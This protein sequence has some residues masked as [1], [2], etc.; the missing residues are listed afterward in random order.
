MSS[1]GSEQAPDSRSWSSNVLVRTTAV[2]L[3]ATA[4]PIAS[5]VWASGVAKAEVEQRA[6]DGLVSTAKATVLQEQQAWEDAVRVITSAASRPV[7]L[8]ALQSRDESLAR[9][10]LQN[11]LITGPFADVRLFDGVG[12][13]VAEAAL[14]GVTPTPFGGVGGPTPGFGDPVDVGPGTARQVAVAIGP[15]GGGRLVVDVDVTQ[16]LGKPSDLAFG[17]TGLKFLVTSDGM[18]VAGSTAVGTML[19]SVLNRSIAAAGH[20]AAK[21]FH[22]PSDESRTVESYEPLPGPSGMGILVQQSRSEAMGGAD[23]LAGRLRWAALAVGVLGATFAVALGVFLSRRSRRLATSEARLTHAQAESRRRLEQ[24]LDAI[25]IGVFVATPDGQPHYANREAARLLGRGIVPGVPA[26]ERAEVFNAYVAGTSELYPVTETP[27]IRALEGKTTH[28]DDMEIRRQGVTVPVEVWGA[29]VL[30]GDSTVEFGITA[31]ADVSDRRRAARELQVLSAITAN[32]SEGVVLVR[33][34]DSTIAYA[35]GSYEAMF[36]YEPGELVGRC[37]RDL[38]SPEPADSDH[39]PEIRGELLA[40][41]TWRGELHGLRKDGSSLW[42][43]VN[44][45]ALEHPTLGPAWIQVTTD[46]T[47]RKLAQEGQARLASIVEA[48]RDAILG[49]TLDGV[50]TSWNH[51]AEV[52]F[53]YAAAEMIGGPIELLI[54]PEGRNDEAQVRARVAGG[55]GVEHHETVRVRK[56]G[57]VVDVSATLSPIEDAYGRIVGIAT[58]C[59][60]VTDR[61]RAE[62]KFQGLLESAPD[63]IVVVGADGLIRLVNRQTEVLFGWSR[64]EL[65]GRPVEQLMPARLAAHHPGQRTSYFANPS[66]RAMGANLELAARRKDGSEFPVDISLSPLETEEGVLVSAA[67]RD[68]T[69]R[70][71]AEAA[72]LDREEQLAAARDEAL[73]ASRLKSQFLANMSHEIRT[74]MNGVLG[75]AQLLLT[76][77]L[78]PDQRRRML[79]LHESGQSLLT[80]INDILDVSK[81]EAGKMELEEA[82]FNLGTTINSVV[83][84]CSSS[85]DD[86][87]LTLTV[88]VARGI[89]EVVRGDAFRLRQ[90]LVNIVGNAVKFTERG[91]VALRVTEGEAGNL[92]F[93]VRDTGIG[94]DSSAKA[95]LLEPFSQADASTTR[96]FGGTGL[97]LAICRQL[98]GL[99]GGSLDFSSEPGGGT[100][101]W[102]ELNLPAASTDGGDHRGSP[103]DRRTSSPLLAGGRPGAV[104]GLHVLLVDD[105]EINREVGKGLVESLGYEVDT[106]SSGAEA[107]EAVRRGDYTAVLMDCLMPAMDG[108]QATGHIRRLDGAVGH[109]PIIALTAAAMSHD[110]DRCLAAGMDDYVTKPLDIGRLAAVLGR[111]RPGKVTTP[112]PAAAAGV[113]GEAG[114][115][116]PG[117]GREAALADRLGLIKNSLPPEAF[118]RICRLFISGTPELIA[119]LD[120]ATRAGDTDTVRSVAHNLKG[121]MAT[122]GAARLSALAERLQEGAP[123]TDAGAVLR[124]MGEEYDKARTVVLSLMAPSSGG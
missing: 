113:A 90:I 57:T 48:S 39:V 6:V 56:D 92:R 7:P 122:V 54:P 66:V 17:K 69:E 55:L 12:N 99:M 34:D 15:G 109:V 118:D 77:N 43:A 121:T 18:I 104:S 33:A 64:S 8:S 98:V 53:G 35:N 42:C 102:F 95:Y 10:G 114:P 16:L 124:Q 115:H 41:E 40:T 81:M 29:A 75:M 67:V 61:K 72:L 111:C 100:T 9:Q 44:V 108:Y 1:L 86:K 25:P 50:V 37:I 80:I 13:L 112:P 65:V 22:S 70:K 79:L 51:G 107:V 97:G 28:I 52:L 59:R 62:A 76:G 83:S 73:E 91:G 38:T 123:A 101:F 68:V 58:I 4:V 49:K 36:G 88:D 71:R 116:R 24:V 47:S 3:M 119:R 78:E 110:R 14:P 84:L 117:E 103:G 27:L 31:V 105:V 26:D 20:P 46:I 5:L 96:R 82:N 19:P 89:P 2:L 32:M 94:L 85:A 106:V 30:G 74:P 45:T 60:D 23:D 21:V 120:A 63:A 87:G 93:T 11:V